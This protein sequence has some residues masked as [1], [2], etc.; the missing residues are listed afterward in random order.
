MSK[1]MTD[2]IRAKLS[3]ILKA[4]WASGTRKRNPPNPHAIAALLSP[5]VRARALAGRSRPEVRARIGR[6]LSVIHKGRVLR[7]TPNSPDEV[8]AFI[9]M[10]KTNPA[11]R[12]GVS[13]VHAQM[14]HI[15]SPENKAYRFRNLTHF[16]REHE[17]LFMPD[18][19]IW[20]PH[21][22]GLRCKAVAGLMKMSP[23]GKHPSPWKGWRWVSELERQAGEMFT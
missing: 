22:S 20:K 10:L 5:E 15:R 19:V 14:W 6:A 23:R 16:V 17:H 3:A 11:T 4:K 12:K 21:G 7:K 9:R 2:E 13:N 1:P 8:A 18:D